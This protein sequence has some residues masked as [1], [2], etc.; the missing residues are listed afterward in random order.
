VRLAPTNASV[1][2]NRARLLDRAGRS[3]DALAD[4]EQAARLGPQSI[5]FW[6]ALGGAYAHA[7]RWTD[8]RTAFDAAAALAKAQNRPDLLGTITAAIASLPKGD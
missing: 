5:E 4:Y 8:A 1:R 2:E 6:Y 3:A 7:R